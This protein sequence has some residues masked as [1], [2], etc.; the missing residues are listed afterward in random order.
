MGVFECERCGSTTDVTLISVNDVDMKYCKDCRV[1][2]FTKKHS[3]GRPSL[4]I[5]KK[6]S[7][8]L[9]ENEWNQLDEKAEGNRSKFIRKA[10]VK[11]LDN[12]ASE[13]DKIYFKSDHHKEQTALILEA[14]GKQ[15]IEDDYFY[16][17]LAYVVG[18]TY[19]ADYLL[20]VIGTDNIIDI[21]KMYEDIKELSHSERV[22]IRFGLQLFGGIDDIELSKVMQPL[23]SEN[24]RVIK[25]AIDIRY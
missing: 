24:T 7:L 25:Q 14:F 22:M 5:T 11:E 10:V 9:P 16:G 19:K 4:G 18:A 3:V 21:E 17:S 13:M 6:V 2:L 1:A 23:D 15:N 12:D 20:K 8:T